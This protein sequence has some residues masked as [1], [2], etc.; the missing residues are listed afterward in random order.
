MLKFSKLCENDIAFIKQTIKDGYPRCSYID[1]DD[2]ILSKVREMLS[3]DSK[4]D[5]GSS[6]FDVANVAMN[7]LLE[8]LLGVEWTL[9]DRS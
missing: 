4:F 1:C 2:C 8:G 3:H 9:N 5:K 6:C 7:K